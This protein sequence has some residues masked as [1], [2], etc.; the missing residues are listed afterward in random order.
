[1][2]ALIVALF[3]LVVV[4][5]I[6]LVAV[7]VIEFAPLVQPAVVTATPTNTP[8][9]VIIT[10]TPLPTPI[11][12]PP[13]TLTP[14]PPPPTQRPPAPTIAPPPEPANLSGNWGAD[15]DGA[16]Y[17]LSIA[18]NGHALYGSLDIKPPAGTGLMPMR[19][20]LVNSSEWEGRVRIQASL[21]PVLMTMNMSLVLS[22]DGASLSGTWWDSNGGSGAITFQRL[23]TE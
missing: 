5:S 18:Q 7:L 1:M 3:C 9:Y 6:V 16:S 13:P 11:P 22:P 14:V 17:V 10:P 20:Q 12:P 21:E 4:L 15:V 19:G 2:R 8:V 23:L